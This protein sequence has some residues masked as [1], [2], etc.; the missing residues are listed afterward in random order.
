MGE[1]IRRIDL[2]DWA[3]REQY[4]LYAGLDFPYFGLT[5]EVDVGPLRRALRNRSLSFTIGLVHVLARAA[6]AVPSFRQRI[7]GDAVIEHAV[8]HPAITVLRP[9]ELFSFCTL[10]YDEDFER[11][12]EHAAERIDRAR[13][14]KSLYASG[15]DQDDLLFMTALPWISFSGFVHPVPLDPPDSVPRIAWGRFAE[16]DG[17]LAM[18]LNVQAH[19]GLIDGIH[20]ARFYERVEELIGDAGAIL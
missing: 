9:G 10:P 1:G 18:P 5:V 3:R 4:E 13:A 11:F 6:N 8:V 7:R 17:R 16:R 2:E 19:H 15:A 12:S 20:V 14:S